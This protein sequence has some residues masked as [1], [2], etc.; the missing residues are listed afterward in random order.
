MFAALLCLLLANPLSEQAVA[1]GF[2][3]L[4][5][6]L[7]EF[8]TERAKAGRELEKPQ[9]ATFGEL[10][11]GQTGTLH[12]RLGGEPGI[13]SSKIVIKQVI[14]SEH[15]IAELVMEYGVIVPITVSTAFRHWV[16][17]GTE[18]KEHRVS[19]MLTGWDLTNV[20]DG[21]AYHTLGT[22]L[23]EGTH[24]YVTAA[25]GT[26]TIPV[27]HPVEIP[28]PPGAGHRAWNLAPQ[29]DALNRPARD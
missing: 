28:E 17:N 16:R 13:P 2:P 24:P 22:L 10:Q 5:D 11:Q 9:L 14:D 1:N 21:Q 12:R 23:V 25:G 7:S 29:L 27:V 4:K 6:Q 26:E 20:S 8:Y 19:V 18:G 3:V 15:A